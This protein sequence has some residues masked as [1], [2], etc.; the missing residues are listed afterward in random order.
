MNDVNYTLSSMYLPV[1]VISDPC[2]GLDSLNLNKL[3]TMTFLSETLELGDGLGG[4]CQGSDCG[5]WTQAR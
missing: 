3:F 4:S 2:W 5:P 1:Y